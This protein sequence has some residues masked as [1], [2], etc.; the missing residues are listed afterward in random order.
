[1]RRS[2]AR[3]GFAVSRFS[4]DFRVACLSY[5]EALSAW[6]AADS[7]AREL[8]LVLNERKT[9]TPGIGRYAASLT[10]VR[11]HEQQL[12]ADLEV[13]ALDEPEY[14]DDEDWDMSDEEED[15]HALLS[16]P[17]FDEGEVVAD[18]DDNGAEND[19]GVS[20]AQLTAAR[21]VLEQW[22]SSED[23]TTQHPE[24]AQVTNT[25]LGRALRVL[26]RAEDVSALEYLT[27]MLVYEPSLTPTIARYARRCIGGAPRRVRAALDQ[28]C[29]S[30]IVSAWQ[31]VWI[32]YVCGE[33][34]PTRRRNPD[35]Q[36]TSWLRSQAQ[37]A[38]SAIASEAVLA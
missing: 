11:D 2:L 28:T 33:V 13:E 10:A 31:A 6:E 14:F 5:Q 24:A 26:A 19:V 38:N 4:D 30:G 15:V 34:P 36:H 9:S 3:A 20:P 35:S 8:G 1:M 27:R 23:D 12:F 29:D 17:E 37:S 32:A 16:E 18:N 22:A 25:L 21:T 7:A